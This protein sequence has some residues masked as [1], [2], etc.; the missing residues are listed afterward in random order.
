MCVC[1]C[2]RACVRVCGSPV[3]AC[4]HTGRHTRQSSKVSQYFME[5][6]RAQLQSP[7]DELVVKSKSAKEQATL[8]LKQ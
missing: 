8:S 4:L 7:R 2:V 1:V 3:P 5:S 6:P